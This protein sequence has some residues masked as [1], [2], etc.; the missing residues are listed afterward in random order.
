MSGISTNN[1]L[2]I[3]ICKQQNYNFVQFVIFVK[4]KI[5]ISIFPKEKFYLSS[6][7]KRMDEG[8][9]LNWTNSSKNE[10]TKNKVI[11]VYK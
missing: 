9:I 5:T 8:S 4:N 10:N 11:N 3:Q 1:I 7:R 6:Y 2:A